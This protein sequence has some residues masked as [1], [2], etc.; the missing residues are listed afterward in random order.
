MIADE[1]A[2]VPVPNVR[3][4]FCPSVQTRDG[5]NE[6]DEC[7]VEFHNMAL[8]I[9]S[10][11]LSTQIFGNKLAAKNEKER[12]NMSVSLQKEYG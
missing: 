11:T 8:V 12:T 7:C 1:A 9:K 4:Y 3:P 2:D 6:I 5:E 10:E